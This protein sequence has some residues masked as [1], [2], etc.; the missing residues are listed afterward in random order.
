MSSWE[1]FVGAGAAAVVT[2]LLLK[3]LS[4]S[5]AVAPGTLAYSR[6]AR[7]FAT[8]LAFGPTLVVATI[9]LFQSSPVKDTDR[10]PI[11]FLMTLFPA[12]GV[13]LV[14]EF[15]RVKHRYDPAQIEFVSPWSANRSL[16]WSQVRRVRWRQVVKWL[17]FEGPDGSRALHI[18]PMLSGL[19]E[20]ATL[21]LQRIP[22]SVLAADPEAL[23]ALICMKH[24]LNSALVMGE[25]TPSAIQ[26]GLQLK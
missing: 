4:G 23:A 10:V 18:S 3:L 1:G 25:K 26:A 21:A 11:L 24:G 13:P 15:F 14:L 5:A 22:P 9:V 12:L 20:F 2:P 19:P 16:E 17:D 6:G 8:L 7:V